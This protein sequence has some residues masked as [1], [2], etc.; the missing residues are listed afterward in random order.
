MTFV[1]NESLTEKKLFEMVRLNTCRKIMIDGEVH[2]SVAY[3]SGLFYDDRDIFR[4][5]VENNVDCTLG[6]QD[7]ARVT[8]IQRGVTSGNRHESSLCKWFAD[9]ME[10]LKNH[11]LTGQIIPE[12]LADQFVIPKTEYRT[13]IQIQ[14]VQDENWFGDRMMLHGSKTKFTASEITLM[15]ARMENTKNVINQ[16]K[17]LK[18]L[19]E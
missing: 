7:P 19:E 11:P 4:F 6:K 12:D 3:D 2:E 1:D 5:D 10:P 15:A 17:L 14:C 9:A 13:A 16:A 8:N 18:K